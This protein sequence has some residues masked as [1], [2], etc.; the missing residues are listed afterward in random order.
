MNVY[1]IFNIITLKNKQILMSLI[2]VYDF[3]YTIY[4]V[5]TFHL[6]QSKPTELHSNNSIQTQTD[7]YITGGKEYKIKPSVITLLKLC[8]YDN[9][10]QSSLSQ[11]RAI[12][13]CQQTTSIKTYHFSCNK[14]QRHSTFHFVERRPCNVWCKVVKLCTK[15]PSNIKMSTQFPN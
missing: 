14:K 9:C 1:T 7:L 11:I 5:Y 6:R 8:M 2:Q 13:I 12:T 3:H 4:G 10:I 15:W